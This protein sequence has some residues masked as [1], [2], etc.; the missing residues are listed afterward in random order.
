MQLT[1]AAFEDQGMIPKK[2]TGEGDDVSP[3]LFWS[4]VPAKTKSFALICNDPD[5]PPAPGRDIPYVHWVL[6]NLSPTTSFLPE[7]AP[8]E[9]RQG[10]NSFGK[11][12]YG[13]PMP[14]V[15]HGIHHYHFELYALDIEL[16]LNVGA[17][18]AELL[19]AIEGHVIQTAELVGLYERLTD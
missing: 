2:F 7:G 10:K 16:D 19:K 9:A 6:Y 13:G 12:G 11:M 14:P 15:G 18:K 17:S 5:A 4:Q 1:S 8:V 3:A